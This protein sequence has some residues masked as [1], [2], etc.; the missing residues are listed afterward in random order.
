M[1]NTELAPVVAGKL[2]EI[3][4]GKIVDNPRNNRD[5]T[6]GSDAL[7]WNIREHGLMTPLTVYRDDEDGTYVILSGHR[8]H[9]ALMDNGCDDSFLTPCYVLPRPQTEFEEEALLSSG[10]H[11]RS[12]PEQ[13]QQE[14]LLAAQTW[15]G[16][17]EKGK[18]IALTAE[19]KKTLTEQY[20]D[21]FIKA[22]QND[23]RY[24]ANP[25]KFMD[26]YFRAKLEYIRDVTG[27]TMSNTTVKETLRKALSP[28]EQ[29]R[30]TD[31][32]KTSAMLA[33]AEDSASEE[34]PKKMKTIGDKQ[35][36]KQVQKLRDMLEV[37]T[38][39]DPLRAGLCDELKQD[40]DNL[41][42]AYAD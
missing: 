10:N 3:P 21:A 7:A 14:V 42:A 33:A 6:S 4:L 34:A 23:E 26:G 16:T 28:E 22:H 9:H 24:L 15:S 11:H 37:A 36:K 12:N 40:L 41:L 25:A 32:A 8:R 39:E 35:I 19:E 2:E 38:I 18:G 1:E 20:H 29:I 13:V 5:L 27:L 30:D 17:L 31:N